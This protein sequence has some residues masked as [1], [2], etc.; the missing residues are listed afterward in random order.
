MYKL[1][2]FILNLSIKKIYNFLFLSDVK[3]TGY[4]SY[5]TDLYFQFLLNKF[6]EL[7]K[8]EFEKGT[9]RKCGSCETLFYDFNKSPLICPSC[10]ADVNI[11]TNISKRGRPPKVVKAENIAPK[12]KDANMIA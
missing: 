10:G 3:K 9:K 4:F 6:P 8:N 2:T 5:L 7:N 12:A 11:L 1:K